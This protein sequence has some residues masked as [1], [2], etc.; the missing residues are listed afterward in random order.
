MEL[1]GLMRLV[2]LVLLVIL[3]TSSRTPAVD[4]AHL[5]PVGE[6]FDV[7]P[8]IGRSYSRVCEQMLFGN[9]KWL[10]RYYSASESVTTG[11]SITTDA[12]GRYSVSVRQARPELYSVVANAYYR[13]LNLQSALAAVKV[14]Q[15]DSE[16]PEAV[17]LAV[18]GLWVSLLTNVRSDE[19]LR[20]SYI[21][22]P[23]VILYA[24]TADRKILQGKMPP[25]GFRDANLASVE[26]VVDDLLKVCVE[27]EEKRKNVFIRIKERTAAISRE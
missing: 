3:T 6:M 11:L 1:H 12:Q 24:R 21:L 27:P 19:K 25:A 8:P 16:I 23:Q 14:N 26:D 20:D 22:S 2:L 17:A 9:T 10:L 7:G 13:K 5:L 15:T 18:H 4:T